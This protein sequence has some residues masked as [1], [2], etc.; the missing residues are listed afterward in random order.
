M[1]KAKVYDRNWQKLR[2][3][4]L[5]KDPLCFFHRKAGLLVRATV[6]DHITPIREDASKRLVQENLQSLCKECHDSIKQRIERGT[7]DQIGIDGLP[8]NP[9]HPWNLNK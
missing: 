1:K 9:T 5:K 2:R 7:Y 6:A 4:Q 8:T 3:I